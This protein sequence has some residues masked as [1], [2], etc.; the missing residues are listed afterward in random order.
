[1]ESRVILLLSTLKLTG[2]H[3]VTSV[4]A[5][6]RQIQCIYAQDPFI[7]SIPSWTQF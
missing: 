2:Q 6:S 4:A 7:V 1:M 5:S 3:Y